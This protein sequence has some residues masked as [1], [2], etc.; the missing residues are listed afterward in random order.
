MST[1]VITIQV[2]L[3]DLLAWDTLTL[4]V[5]GG[6]GYWARARHITRNPEARDPNGLLT[7]DALLVTSLQVHGDGDVPTSWTTLD[8]AT[9]ARGF[10]LALNGQFVND[11]L[12]GAI[13]RA[14]ANDDGAELDAEAADC[15][16][17]LG[18]FGELIY[19]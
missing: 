6:I 14:L 17:Q 13:F 10:D 4:A 5:E 12:K 1:H 7:R 3:S 18:L 19:G 8:K 16:V 11:D 2:P 9:V 15:I